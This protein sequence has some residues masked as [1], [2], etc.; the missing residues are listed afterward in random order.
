MQAILRRLESCGD[1]VIRIF[2]EDII[3][4]E[5][6]EKW[7]VVQCLIAFASSGFPLTKCQ[8]YCRLVKPTLVN[9]VETQEVFRSRKTVYRTL[10]EWSI[11]CPDHV[12]VDHSACSASDF[13][14]KENYI[15]YNGKRITKPFVEKPIDGDRHDIWIYYPK[16]IGGGAKKLFRKVKDKSSE[17]DANQ[18]TIRRDGTYIY[19]PF[20]PTQGTDI[21]VYTVGSDYVHAEARKAPTVDGKVQRAPDGKEIRYPVVLTQQEKA[22]SALIV[23]AF[24]SQVCGFDILRTDGGSIVCDVNGWSFVK[25]NQKY[26]NDCSALIRRRFLQERGLVNVDSIVSM[27]FDGGQADEMEG[28]C[29]NWSPEGEKRKGFRLRSVLVV[30]RH[31]D[32]R[33]KE[34]MKFKTKLPVLLAYLDDVAENADEVKITLPEEMKILKTRMESAVLELRTEISAHTAATPPSGGTEKQQERVAELWGD[35]RNIE[36][37]IEVLAMQDRFSG[38]ERKVQLK[39]SK[40]KKQEEDGASRKAAQVLVVAKW[41]GE[42]TIHGL[43]QSQE[44]GSQLR[45]GLYPNDPTG[46]LRLHS[47]FRHD[48]K[49]YSSQ[50]GRCQITAAAF[51]KGFLDLEGDIIPILV[52]LVSSDRYAQALLDAPIPRKER[53]Q[54]KTK[55]ESLLMSYNDLSSDEVLA[56]A[57][58]TEHRCL[59]EAARRI[60]S[61]LKLL[62]KVRRLADEYVESIA[63]DKEVAYEAMRRHNQESSEAGRASSNLGTSEAATGDGSGNVATAAASG[64]YPGSS[65]RESASD[66]LQEGGG[67]EGAEEDDEGHEEA[68]PLGKAV[69]QGPGPA[70]PFDLKD[71][72]KRNFLHLKRKEHRW[73]KVLKGF[74]QASDG[75]SSIDQDNFTYDA[76]KIPEVWDNV[77]YD[78]LAH[79]SF[80]GPRSIEISESLAGI[81]HPLNEWVCLSEYGISEDEKL[82]IGTDVTWRLIG[83]ILGDLE[84]MIDANMCEAMRADVG[85]FDAAGLMRPGCVASGHRASEGNSKADSSGS[86]GQALRLPISQDV[87]P[88]MEV[89][90]CPSPT[91]NSSSNLATIPT[92]GIQDG[93]IEAVRDSQ[94]SPPSSQTRSACTSPRPNASPRGSSATSAVVQATKSISKQSCD[95]EIEGMSSQTHMKGDKEKKLTRLGKLTPELRQVLKEALCDNTEWHPRLNDEVAK[96]TNIKDTRTVRSRIYVTSASTMHSL[97][98][99]LRHGQIAS[100]DAGILC[101]ADLDKVMDLNYLTHL[102]FRCYEREDTDAGT[103]PPAPKPASDSVTESVGATATDDDMESSEPSSSGASPG[104]GDHASGVRATGAQSA[105]QVRSQEKARYKVEIAMSPGV[106]LF[107]PG[108]SEHEQWPDPRNLNQTNCKVAPLQII[109]DVDLETLEYFLMQVVKEYGGQQKGESCDEDEKD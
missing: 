64:G 92:G 20:L 68:V 13:M 104:I 42:L 83:K 12:I 4:N 91:G 29:P 86:S 58:P 45:I 53:C 93:E 108:T 78:L 59:K 61:P 96:L 73:R 5:P 24:N 87:Q 51:T 79:R 31:G 54:V 56:K 84:Y 101:N 39:A 105:E 11:P 17:F 62:H 77:Y 97:F 76:S 10:Q 52:S 90:P 55:I 22:I 69:P 21:K 26:Y 66:G 32:R 100:G 74:S 88:R 75:G 15:V 7:P 80:L 98:N 47:S 63:S 71:T 57:C 44:L 60:L 94:F 27:N 82:R 70:I 85:R 1:F 106:Q 36:T 46:L 89:T 37:L 48:F 109:A 30:M 102:V 49:I 28:T 35:L 8:A 107:L 81:L 41:G 25:G 40:W 23:Q 2:D 9:D 95:S 19:E 43:E 72:Y 38:L 67:H 33:P 65:Q 16:S 103:A 6:I 18:N 99:I 14:E 3:V 50:E 34:K